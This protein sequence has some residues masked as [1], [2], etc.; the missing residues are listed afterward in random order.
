MEKS[1]DRQ[2]LQL[3]HYYEGVMPVLP[4]NTVPNIGLLLA[5]YWRGVFWQYW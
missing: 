2:F 5:Q 1:E 4:V 3:A